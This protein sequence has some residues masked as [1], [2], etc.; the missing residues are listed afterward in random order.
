[1][2]LTQRIMSDPCG[3]AWVRWLRVTYSRTWTGNIA[4]SHSAGPWPANRPASAA[5]TVNAQLQATAREKRFLDY[6]VHAPVAIHHLGHC[7][8]DADG[9]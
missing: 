4:T 6:R 8:V 2:S 1:M 7:E 5:I 9:D 3:H